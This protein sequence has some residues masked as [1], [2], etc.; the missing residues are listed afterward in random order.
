M[1]N[2]PI[3]TG[4]ETLEPPVKITP[5]QKIR[6]LWNK[7]YSKKKIFWPVTIALG[8]LLLVLIAGMLFGTRN[9]IIK[10]MAPTPTPQASKTPEAESTDPLTVINS[11]LVKLGIQIKELDIRQ[12]RLSPPSVDFDIRF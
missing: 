9:G 1:N 8:F 2:Q 10:T 11:R 12:S 5:K 6:E 3:P 7:F 4:I